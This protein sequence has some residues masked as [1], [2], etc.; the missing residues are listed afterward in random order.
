MGINDDAP[1]YQEPLMDPNAKKFIDDSI[2]NGSKSIDSAYQRSNETLKQGG[3]LPS[4]ESSFR[5]EE[6]LGR[7]NKAQTDAILKKGENLFSKNVRQMMVQNQLM[8]HKQRASTLGQKYQLSARQWQFFDQIRQE[9]ILAEQNK[10]AA[11]NAVIGQVFQLGGMAIGF[12]AGGPGGAMVGQQLGKMASPNS[13]PQSRRTP[14]GNGYG[15]FNDRM[16]D[17]YDPTGEI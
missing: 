3:L 5:A 6:S 14:E 1:D 7:D 16:N 12:A 10:I 11:R 8:A 17:Q 9:K 4:A 15:D 2:A 13:K